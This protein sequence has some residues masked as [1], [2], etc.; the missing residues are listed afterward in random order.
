MTLTSYYT[1][2]KNANMIVPVTIGYNAP[3]SIIPLLKHH[4]AKQFIH[5]GNWWN[6]KKSKRTLNIVLDR[7]LKLSNKNT[8]GFMSLNVQPGDDPLYWVKNEQDDAYM[9]ECLD[10]ATWALDKLESKDVHVPLY[11]TLQP[12]DATAAEKWFQKAIDQGHHHLAMGVSEF[13]R[14][15]RHRSEGTKRILEITS[16]VGKML[17]N[18]KGGKFHLSGLM[19]YGLLPVVAFLGATSTDGS[20]P[21]QPALAYGT[22]F[23]PQGKGIQAKKLEEK[24][25][26]AGWNCDCLICINKSKEEL[27]PAFKEPRS[28][29]IHNLHVWQELINEINGEV[30][31]NP[32]KWFQVNEQ[33][34]SRNAIKAWSIA[35]KLQEQ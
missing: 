33:R 9:E 34:L 30:L 20:T 6:I 12:R 25:E 16:I 19:S 21:V 23:S 27:I 24:I 29:V 15:P 17:K 35:F 32:Q 26:K 11:C 31:K 1:F 7:Q 22:V 2:Y 8:M 28:R 4:A 14:Y 5:S 10:N 13:L 18:V 3:D